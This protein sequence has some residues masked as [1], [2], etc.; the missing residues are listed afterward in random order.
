MLEHTEHKV[1]L[2]PLTRSLIK[3]VIS[4]KRILVLPLL[5]SVQEDKQLNRITA[6]TSG[7]GS[8]F[9]PLVNANLAF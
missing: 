2:L 4:F 3:I 5:N 9:N 6:D 1:K 8:A 7:T